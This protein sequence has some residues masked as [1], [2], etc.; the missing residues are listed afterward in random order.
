V[1]PTIIVMMAAW[2]MMQMLYFIC[3]IYLRL[4]LVVVVEKIVPTKLCFVPP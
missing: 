2:L 1:N 3:K 4:I